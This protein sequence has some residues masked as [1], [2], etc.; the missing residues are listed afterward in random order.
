M[1]RRMARPGAGRGAPPPAAGG[2]GRAELALSQAEFADA[3]RRALRDLHRP[4][5]LAANPLLRSRVVRDA[6]AGRPPAEALSRPARGGR[7]RA[8]RRPARRQAAAR[9]GPHLPAARAHPGGRR[10]AARPAL[11]HLPR[12]PDARPRAGR[13]LALAARALRRPSR[14][15]AH[16]ARQELGRNSS[17]GSS[18]RR[19][20]C[21]ASDRRW[22]DGTDRRA[23]GGDRRQRGRAAGGPR[24]RRRVRARDGGRARRAAG[25]ASRAAGRCRRAATPTP[26]CRRGQVCLEALLPGFCRRAVRRGRAR[27]RGPGADARSC[28]AGTS[29][30]ARARGA[31][32]LFASR[33]FI[34]GHVRRRVRALPAVEADRRLRRA[35]PDRHRR[36]RR[37]TGVR[38]PAPA[39]GS[40]EEA[41]AGRPGRRRHRPRRPACRPG[42]RPSA[43]RGR[44]RSGCDVGVTYASRH[45]RLPAGA[46]RRRQDGAH[47][48]ASRTARARCSCSRR[49]TAAGSSSL[50]GY[51]PEHRPPTDPDGHAASPRPSRR[52]TCAEALE[53]AE[54]LDDDR[55][56]PLPRQPPPPLRAAARLP[57]G[58]A[59][60]AATRSARSTPPTG[61]G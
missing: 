53:A 27:V 35:R 48:R 18:A 8:A 57:G 4:G 31:G 26:C 59:G 52:P 41:L 9:P 1:A 14:A 45:L 2:R 19:R 16:R 20:A 61:R 22:G 51:G 13:R 43:T 36:R 5:A 28:S 17:G 39:D 49:R 37:V 10:R 7:R 47:R 34:E 42:S 56:P 23:R 12:P 30:P 6:A 32:S 38:D 55:H 33:P 11:Q 40:A 3:V 25:R 60:R 46:A 50:G 15:P 58:A 21:A 44:P 54:P 24:A 29:S